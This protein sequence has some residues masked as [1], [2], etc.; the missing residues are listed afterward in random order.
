M[1]IVVELYVPWAF[2][3]ESLPL[4]PVV[5]VMPEAPS[6]QP[7]ASYVY[8]VVDFD[9]ELELSVPVEVVV[10]EMESIFKLP[11]FQVLVEVLS[12]MVVLV[13]VV[14]VPPCVVV[15]VISV[16]VFESSVDL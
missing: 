1:S 12:E 16:V 3:L 15:E 4:L 2:P 7:L 9:V 5:I 14:V 10:P 6:K 8:V 11:P 13:V